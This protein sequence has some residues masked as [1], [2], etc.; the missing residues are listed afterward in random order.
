MLLPLTGSEK[1]SA[2]GGF[3][4]ICFIGNFSQS[5]LISIS[6]LSFFFMYLEPAHCRFRF[7]IRIL[8]VKKEQKGREQCSQKTDE[9]K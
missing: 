7:W 2:V 5:L 4:N 8:K 9:T 3:S 6:I 1:Y